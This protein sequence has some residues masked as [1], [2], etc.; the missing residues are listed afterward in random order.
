MTDYK[1]YSNKY[2]KILAISIFALVSC[3]LITC[4]IGLYLL[5]NE[6]YTVKYIHDEN[7][8]I[9]QT[10]YKG[11]KILF[12][13]TPTKT[14]Y[15]FVGWSLNK[16]EENILTQDVYV[17]GELT[18][19]AQW[20]ENVYT[21]SYGD[22]DIYLTHE[23]T[24]LQNNNKLIIIGKNTS[25]E[26]SQPS[27]SSKTFIEWT[28]YDGTQYYSL[29]DFSFDNLYTQQLQLIPQFEDIVYSF[30][31]PTSRDFTI[32]NLSHNNFINQ[33]DTL[34]FTLLL[35]NRV[36][37]ST[38]NIYSSSGNVYVNTIDK[39]FNVSI[40]NFIDNFEVIIDN[41][42]I[43]TYNI[44]FNNNGEQ[45]SQTI[46]HGGSI[47]S[48]QFSRLG[49]TLIG[50]RDSNNNIYHE[51]D[52]V[53]SNLILDVIW[54]KNL[55]SITLPRN[56]GMFALLLESE[57]LSA[58]RTIYKEYNDSIEFSVILSKAYNHS[59][60]IVYGLN[61]GEKILPTAKDSN[62]FIFD[63]IQCNMEIVISN[64]SLNYYNVVIDGENYGKVSYGS[65]IYIEDTT[66][67]VRDISTNMI[68]EASSLINN[69]EFH[70]WMCNNENLTTCMIQD[71]ADEN[72]NVEIYG[73]YTKKIAKVTLVA[74]GGELTIT[75][76]I[77]VE[78]EENTLPTPTR[79]GYIFAGWYTK[80]V[81]I[82]TEV[83]IV[84]STQFTEITSITTTLYAGWHKII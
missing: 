24:F 81:E 78:G 59:N 47:D 31:L 41:I 35:S 7:N 26:I 8:I 82:N 5:C 23:H 61:G 46:Q 36:N 1:K 76:L 52:I 22:Q 21:L 11:E 43:N 29:S 75:E 67:C 16:D 39:G 62:V 18:L 33:C 25:I 70:G 68:I 77:I 60:Y 54:E 40:S 19:Y 37:L 55:Y 6:V 9:V 15:S 69:N 30:T 3:I 42:N 27:Q 20:K 57:T 44:T 12:P 38:P 56:N 65:W 10:Y 72:G 17:D 64:I 49:Y 13:E 50:F 14:G 2:K 73:I 58:N 4:S 48:N 71:V 63:N 80:L 45:L 53:T 32:T 83:D 28:I 79:Q 74:N 34:S 51:G 84:S 66:I